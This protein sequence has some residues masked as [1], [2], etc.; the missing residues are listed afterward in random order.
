MRGISARAGRR[1]AAAVTVG[2]L[3]LLCWSASALGG[4]TPDPD[5]HDSVF[6]KTGG[7]RYAR[8]SGPFN[9]GNSGFASIYTGCGGGDRAPVGG[10]FQ[11]QGPPPANKDVV[12]TEP[13]DWYDT[14]SVPDAWNVSGF[15]GSAGT[16]TSYAICSK[17]QPRFRRLTV[18]DGTGNVR[19]AK[20]GCD[21]KQWHAVSGGGLIAT[22]DSRI[23]SSYPY[24]GPDGDKRPDDGW[25]V[26]V[27]DS[28]GGFGGFQ[29]YTVCVK[30]PVTYV[31]E[32]SKGKGP[33]KQISQSL[34]CT[35]KEHAVSVGTK[36]S[37][38]GSQAHLTNGYPFDDQDE[39]QAF[40]D[41]F[42][43]AAF[44]YAGDKKSIRSILTCLG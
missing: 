25:A 23:N 20:V 7:L 14:D 33:G 22:T 10:G 30:G 31:A 34:D 1:A 32:R 15:G 2:M 29:I 37:G 43:A 41:G 17:D 28:G 13:Y 6:G 5:I 3:A 40:D 44:N 21:G 27:Y 12:G 8:D 18:P 42:K 24:D 11:L 16:L 26:R 36:V 19:T 35:P 9:L 39:D 4:S 38:D